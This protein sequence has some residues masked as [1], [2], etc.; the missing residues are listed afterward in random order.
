MIIILRLPLHVTTIGVDISN[1]RFSIPTNLNDIFILKVFLF[2]LRND[3]YSRVAWKNSGL[4][5]C[6]RKF[7]SLLCNMLSTDLTSITCDR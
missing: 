1:D 6:L 5:L 3:S 2:L 7:Y 4:T